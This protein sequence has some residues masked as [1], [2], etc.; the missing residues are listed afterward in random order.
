MDSPNQ[1]FADWAK[2]YEPLVSKAA[3]Q[4][5]KAAEYDD[6]YQEGMIALWN[7][8]PN[9]DQQMVSTAIYNR[10]KN[11]IRYTKRLTRYQSVSYEDILNNA[12]PE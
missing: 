4:F 5:S 9:P 8:Y 7:I 11:W 12:V 1:E 3:W 6:L 2:D 10:M